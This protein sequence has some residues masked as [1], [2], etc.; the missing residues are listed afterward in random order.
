MSP[1]HCVVLSVLHYKTQIFLLSLSEMSQL[2]QED[3]L[4]RLGLNM[5]VTKRDLP[6]P[7]DSPPTGGPATDPG[8]V[9]PA[10]SRG[11][12]GSLGGGSEESWEQ[13]KNPGS[14]TS[15][16]TYVQD[17]SISGLEFCVP[18][19]ILYISSEEFRTFT[20]RQDAFNSGIY[21]MFQHLTGLDQGLD[22]VK[23]TTFFRALSPNGCFVLQTASP[24]QHRMLSEQEVLALQLQE[25]AVHQQA[26]AHAQQGGGPVITSSGLND[27]NESLNQ[28]RGSSFDFGLGGTDHAGKNL[29]HPADLLTLRR[30]ANQQEL[31]EMQ[32]KA[33]R[34]GFVSMFRG[35][36]CQLAAGAAHDL[37]NSNGDLLALLFRL[38]GVENQDY[39]PGV[40]WEQE[41]KDSVLLDAESVCSVVSLVR[42]HQATITELH[43]LLR[44]GVRQGGGWDI[45]KAM[46][47]KGTQFSARFE[48]VDH[49]D[50][51]R[52]EARKRMKQEGALESKKAPKRR[53]GARS[54]SRGRTSCMR[55]PS[56]SPPAPSTS[57]S[58]K[59]SGACFKCASTT[60]YRI[61]G[62]IMLGKNDNVGV[63]AIIFTIRGIDSQLIMQASRLFLVMKQ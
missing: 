58:S 21:K 61:L 36:P 4:A 45:V 29:T 15:L 30:I 43:S 33:Q 51:R 14:L 32:R 2:S 12:E 62:F 11:A 37:N 59:P 63:K 22:Q 34:E 1:E 31:R 56:G 8:K 19:I 55:S 52:E 46:M 48:N 3:I 53:A 24:G 47:N 41:I 26:L 18:G 16:T 23:N 13:D 60:D 49:F 35:V 27:N 39:A 7:V 25:Q 28:T 17:I 9:P 38:C 50:K 42:Q 40:P 57:G 20:L 44:E 6:R 54:S 5:T 10:A